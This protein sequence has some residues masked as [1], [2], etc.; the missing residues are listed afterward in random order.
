MPRG[1][2]PIGNQDTPI[3]IQA[4]QAPR[5]NLSQMISK[6]KAPLHMTANAP[7]KVS[8]RP[9]TQNNMRPK[10]GGSDQQETIPGE[11][12]MQLVTTIM[13]RQKPESRQ[14]YPPLLKPPPFPPTVLHCA[15]EKGRPT[16]QLEGTVSKTS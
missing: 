9:N 1:K 14:D 11:L 15:S 12:V 16:V 10:R 3:P 2:E 4:L 13:Q 5:R 6:N 8:Q 7:D